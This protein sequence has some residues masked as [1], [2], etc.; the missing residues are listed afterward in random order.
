MSHTAVRTPT[1]RAEQGEWLGVR[2]EGGG[3]E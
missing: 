2:N 1:K 3:E